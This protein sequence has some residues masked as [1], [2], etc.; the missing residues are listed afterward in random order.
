MTRFLW[1]SARNEDGQALVLVI[2]LIAVLTLLAPLL[3]GAVQANSTGSNDA[4]IRARAHAAAEAGLNDY[5]A[6]LLDNNQYYR[7]Y[8]AP[9]EST[10]RAYGVSPQPADVQSV[11]Q[12]PPST[13]SV[14]WPSSNGINWT[15]P[16]GKDA[17]FNVGSN[18]YLY[19]IQVIPPMQCIP[20]VVGGCPVADPN[21]IDCSK[22]DCKQ[23]NPTNYVRITATGKAPNAAASSGNNQAIQILLQPSSIAAFQ[24]F[25]GAADGNPICYGS[26]A[27]TNGRIY[28]MGNL[29]YAG[30]ANADLLAEGTVVR[31][32]VGNCISGQAHDGIV[33]P[34]AKIYDS[35]G[36]VGT[37]NIR[38]APDLAVKPSFTNFQV[39]LIDMKAAAQKAGG[40]YLTDTTGTASAWQLTFNTNGTVTYAS[41]RHQTQPIQTTKP[42]CDG[43]VAAS[44]VSTINGTT[45]TNG[46]G[47]FTIPVNGSIYIDQSVVI[48]GGTGTCLSGGD[49]TMPNS[50]ISISSASCVKGRVS[51]GSGQD[52][53]VAGNLGYVTPGQDV[54]GLLAQNNTYIPSWQAQNS[55]M[56]WSAAS[57]SETGA[58]GQ[59]KSGGVANSWFNNM[60]HNG[61]LASYTMGGGMLQYNTR[62][63]NYDPNLLTL[64]P[65]WFP[66][67]PKPY[68][69]ISYQTLPNTN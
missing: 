10:R 4:L 64:Q 24:A 66:T 31:T 30:T 62:N 19:N 36:A 33:N 49:G 68:K 69:I 58:W 41:C 38:Q 56:N 21:N 44:N 23:T 16:N 6:K 28:S 26:G 46:T 53:V 2:F 43:T 20:L 14:A 29:Y 25:N 59:P 9:G 18:N 35:S 65:P 34:P 1:K 40:V 45:T 47:T 13:A 39:S 11:S 15:Y 42:T 48:N 55:S 37:T 57:L 32:R 54:L 5:L 60:T 50:H 7:Q 51:V 8:L 67:L 27:T 12:A 61:M 52:I 22:V 3:I 17:W 63:Y